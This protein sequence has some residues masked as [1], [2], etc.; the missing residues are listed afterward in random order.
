MISAVQ[1]TLRQAGKKHAANGGLSRQK[2]SPVCHGWPWE[3]QFHLLLY[4]AMLRGNA[5]RDA[6]KRERS[7]YRLARLAHGAA[8]IIEGQ[9]TA[10]GVPFA[11]LECGSGP[12]VLCL[13][14]FPDS[15]WSFAPLLT[16]I[17]AS[18][19]RAVAPFMRGSA[20]TPVPAET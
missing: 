1:K 9:I 17:A 8:M 3:H 5:T 15:A 13:H 16:A 2:T 18:G 14:G 11:Y 12:L 4:H 19:K 6:C 10:N 7:L 20:P